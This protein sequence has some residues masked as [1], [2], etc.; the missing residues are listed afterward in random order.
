MSMYHY[1]FTNDLRISTLNESLKRAGY[2][3]M[4]D[5]V[6]SAQENKNEN[7]N[8]KTLGFY[9]NLTDKSNC[10][11]ACANGNVRKVVLNFIKKFQFPN[12]RTS[13]SLNDAMDD[14]IMVAPM[15]VV[16]QV[17][18]NMQMLYPEAAYLTREEIKDFVFYNSMSILYSLSITTTP[19]LYFFASS[20]FCLLSFKTSSKSQSSASLSSITFAYF[21]ILSKLFLI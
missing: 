4:T 1:L 11:I 12:P 21:L 6:P 15:R 5:S 14:N 2:C 9:F 7:N 20:K 8:M 17:L 19:T 16:L 10:A 13:E 18:Y 3:F